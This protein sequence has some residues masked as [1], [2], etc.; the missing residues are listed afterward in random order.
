MSIDYSK[1]A[2]PKTPKK[3]KSKPKK[4]KNKSNK[5]AKLEKQ[6]DK[7]IVKKGICEYCGKYSKRLDPH[8]IYGGSNRKRSIKYKFIKLIC[9]ECHSNEDIIR[10]LRIKTQKEYEETH[11]REDFIKL[12]GKNY[13]KEFK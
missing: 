3:D 9:P 4:M 8:E 7:D 12:I 1:F 13:V 2:F 11:T 5:L 6:R 10:Q